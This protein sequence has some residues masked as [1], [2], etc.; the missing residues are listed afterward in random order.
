[1]GFTKNISRF[2]IAISILLQVV[3]AENQT[4]SEMNTH[5]DS[6]FSSKN[7]SGNFPDGGA[8]IFIGCAVALYDAVFSCTVVLAFYFY[9]RRP[10]NIFP[11]HEQND[12]ELKAKIAV[13][14]WRSRVGKRQKLTDSRSKNSRDEDFHIAVD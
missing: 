3:V 7:I 2:I 14:L 12:A 13:G 9:C 8:M 4:I 1:M 5:N 6:A 10:K 11:H